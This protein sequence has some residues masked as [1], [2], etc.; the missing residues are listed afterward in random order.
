MMASTHSA[1]AFAA[2][3]TALLTVSL[4]GFNVP[5]G[6]LLF[7]VAPGL[8]IGALAPDLDEPHSKLGRKYPFVAEILKE[9]FE[10]RG[11]T[12]S[13]LLHIGILVIALITMIF[14][15]F[16]GIFLAAFAIG[17]MLHAAG[18]MMTRGGVPALL[19]IKKKKYWLFSP[20][21]RFYVGSEKE[22]SLL[23][24]FL[25]ATVASWSS[26]LVMS[27]HA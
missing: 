21:K 17:C 10:H 16:I 15:Q 23:F 3:G 4:I 24:V 18:D 27:S 14:D 19:P 1:F 20:A 9:A 12:H 26:V 13:F 5:V 25:V 22:F 7:L 6:Q 11:M 2:A 8:A